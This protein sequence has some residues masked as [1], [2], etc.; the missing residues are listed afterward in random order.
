MLTPDLLVRH[1][2]PGP[3]YTSYPTVPVWQDAPPDALLTEAVAEL[4]G[5]VSVYVH[6]PFCKE[7]CTFCGCNMVVAGRYEVG[8]R[9]L[10]A[11]E[12]QLA[13]L[14][15][16]DRRLPTVRIHLGGGTPTWFQPEELRRLFSALYEHFE[17][18]EGAEVG[19]EV[20]PDVTT[21][22]HV[23]ALAELGV[24]RLS[25]GVQSLDADVLAAVNRPQRGHRVQELLALARAHGMTGLN[26]D[27]MYGLPKQDVQ[28]FTSTLAG[29]LDMAPDRLALFGY[30]HVPWLKRHQKALD[31]QAL[32]GPVGR[33][34]LYLLAQQVLN[35]A[36]YVPIGLDH[37]ARADDALALAL[38]DGSLRRDFMGYT[39]RPHAP[40]LGLGV[41]A[42]SEFPDRFVQQKSKLGAWYRAVEKGDPL[43]ERGYRLTADDRVRSD[44]IERL[45]CALV[46][47]FAPIESRWQLSFADAFA[48][49][50][51]AL[52]PL[53]ADGLVQVHDDRIVVPHEA[54]LLVRNVAMVFDAHLQTPADGPRFSQTV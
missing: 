33:A 46:V 13:A 40:M 9:Y 53:E 2:R 3:R 52:G 37:F 34:A 43:L 25:M 10:D 4:D 11:I 17:P 22:E 28:R 26:L 8:M 1:A 18:V 51:R 41:S 20:D 12:A 45:M 14:P 21:D 48:D 5:P 19:V 38:R 30:A 31:D 35:D 36:G 47:P 27:L 16:P 7:Q 24:T 23:H 29:I 15:L 49:E 44:I 54:R 32:P 42:I 39:D 50:L 6:V